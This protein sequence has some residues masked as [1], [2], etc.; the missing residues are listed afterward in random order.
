MF[1][2]IYQN[3]KIDNM[4]YGVRIAVKQR[5]GDKI[6][7]IHNIDCKEISPELLDLRSVRIGN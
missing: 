1:A 7:W 6:F 2:Y 3:V 5:I 4:E